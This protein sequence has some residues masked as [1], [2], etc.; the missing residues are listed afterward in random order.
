MLQE[1]G[2][3]PPYII[4]VSQTTPQEPQG[5]WDTETAA[6]SSEPLVGQR[7]AGR[8]REKS[9]TQPWGSV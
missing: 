2:L 8:S 9:S 4:S 5:L 1:M 3:T 6:S 7:E